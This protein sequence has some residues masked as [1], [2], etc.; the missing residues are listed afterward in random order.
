MKEADTLEPS[1][2]V[3]L[4]KTK[5]ENGKSESKNRWWLLGAMSGVLG[6]IVLDETVVS[7]ALPSIQSDFEMSASLAHWVINAYLLAFTCFVALAGKMGDV[8]HRRTYFSAGALLFCVAS[9]LA[10]T[11]PNGGT[12]IAA[13]ALQGV[14]AAIIF[15]TSLALITSAFPPS[16]RGVAF[17]Y[18]TT[19]GGVFMASGPL[20]GGLL[21][22]S[23]SW[24]MIFW[25]GIPVVIAITT[26]LWTIWSKDYELEKR[27]AEDPL[28]AANFKNAV[29]LVLGLLALVVPLMQG[30]DWGWTSISTL[31]LVVAGAIL[32]VL[33]LFRETHQPAPLLDLSLLKIPEFAGGA[34]IFAIFQFEKI[35]VF[36]FSAQFFQS[37]LGL[38]PILSGVV[39][40]MAIVPT[41]RTSV[42]VGR[43]TDEHG[44]KKT[45]IYGV[46]IHGVAVA[47]LAVAT[48]TD[49][50]WLALVALLVWGASMPSIA[51]PT[52]RQQMNLVPKE[53]H[54]QAGGINLTLQF[55]GGCLGLAFCSALITETN[56]FPLL[57]GI[58]ALTTL[59]CVRIAQRNIE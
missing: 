56:S 52:R 30:A 7:V 21:T 38:S 9:L 33:F 51:I 18:Q 25:I 2:G 58:V 4:Q 23:L 12:L 1:V 14:A 57:F 11:A 27:E 54:A 19:V 40:S 5:V 36:V 39:L 20:V 22:Q 13:R 50:L 31:G 17:G 24:R 55:F 35:A 29:L 34:T 59:F 44:A 32:S 42:L 48:M 15:P 49:S 45:L 26:V 43:F 37:H 47:V 10:A 28:W 41:L 46:A 53:K 16:E 8:F 6:L 3:V